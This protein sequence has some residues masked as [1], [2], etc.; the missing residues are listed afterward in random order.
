MSGPSILNAGA[1]P[2]LMQSGYVGNPYHHLDFQL[3]P[4]M[5]HWWAKTPTGRQSK[6][7]KTWQFNRTRRVAKLAK[8]KG[9]LV[10]VYVPEIHYQRTTAEIYAWLGKRG[11]NNNCPSLPPGYEWQGPF[12]H[13]ETIAPIAEGP[14]GN[15]LF[16]FQEP[17][18]SAG[19]PVRYIACINDAVH[20]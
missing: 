9:A 5:F 11:H 20:A 14:W 8:Y 16:L 18:A 2:S 15:A 4:V 10:P 1:V 6:F 7:W 12:L 3:A 17:Q 19:L 13:H